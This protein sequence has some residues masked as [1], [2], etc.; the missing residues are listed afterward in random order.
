MIM[1]PLQTVVLFG[2]FSVTIHAVPYLLLTSTKPKCVDVV[3]SRGTTLFIDYH[4]PDMI[5]I[6]EGD[7]EFKE[8]FPETKY[9]DTF[10]RKMEVMKRAGRKF[11]D[12]S[13]V[14][15]HREESV[16]PMYSKTWRGRLSPEE[17]SMDQR[18]SGRIRHEVDET[19]GIFKF[20]TGVNDG[21]VQLCVQSLGAQ[22]DSPSRVSLNVT[23]LPTED[24][25][26][27]DSKGEKEKQEEKDQASAKRHISR[28]SADLI[29]LERKAKLMMLDADDAKTREIQFHEQSIA[30]N[31]ASQYW[32]IIH[33]VVLVITA[34]TQ[35]NHIVRFFKSRNIY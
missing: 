9:T 26:Y 32:P 19:Q 29:G 3:A 5:K 33:L 12:L 30:M 1:S 27:D 16:D 24:S 35:A 11:N 31:R 17:R 34:F 14:V 7:E 20:F 25:H 15:Q 6:P 13:I 22:P 28:M 21:S 23:Q 8:A 10:R 4:A 18:A 2:L